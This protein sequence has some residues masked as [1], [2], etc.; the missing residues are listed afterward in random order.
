[1]SQRRKVTVTLSV[2]GETDRDFY[3]WGWAMA[4]SLEDDINHAN[5]GAEPPFPRV[6]VTVEDCEVSPKEPTPHE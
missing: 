6:I 3:E 4:R 5:E 2:T 1:M